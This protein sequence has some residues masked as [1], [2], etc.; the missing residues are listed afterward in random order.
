M[1][2]RKRTALFGRFLII[3]LL[4]RLWPGTFFVGSFLIMFMTSLG[5]VC[6]AGRAIGVNEFKQ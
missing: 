3:K 6:L 2:V 4:I 1:R 5:L